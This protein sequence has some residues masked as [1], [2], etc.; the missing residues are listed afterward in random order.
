M[1]ALSPLLKGW[2][3]GGLVGSFV[4]TLPLALYDIVPVQF[5]RGMGEAVRWIRL[6]GIFIQLVLR[7]LIPTVLVGAILYFSVPRFSGPVSFGGISLPAIGTVFSFSQLDHKF[8]PS[9]DEPF[10][11]GLYGS[12]YWVGAILCWE[13]A[14]RARRAEGSAVPCP[15][16]PESDLP[17]V[18][19]PLPQPLRRSDFGFI[20]LLPLFRWDSWHRGLQP[21]TPSPP[22]SSFR[23]SWEPRLN[24]SGE[25]VPRKETGLPERS[26]MRWCLAGS[27]KR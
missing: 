21:P 12:G 25:R 27:C 4:I 3:L 15:A 11:V 20:F 26:P 13:V 6:S 18:D 5:G 7:G 17:I 19:Q 2:V 22:A 1:K 24:S 16:N 23:F 14:I 8:Y 9:F 10:M